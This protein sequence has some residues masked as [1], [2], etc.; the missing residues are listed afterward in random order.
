MAAHFQSTNVSDKPYFHTDHTHLIDGLDKLV[1]IASA[2]SES[3]ARAIKGNAWHDNLGKG[4][5]MSK[6]MNCA[7]TTSG[8]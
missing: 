4:G 1:V 7:C 3:A 5:R 8:P 2:S 6:P